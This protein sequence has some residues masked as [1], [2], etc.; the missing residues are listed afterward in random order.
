MVVDAGG[1]EKVLLGMRRSIS[2]GVGSGD[3]RKK[4][5]KRRERVKLEKASH[6]VASVVE[7]GGGMKARPRERR[8]VSDGERDRLE[9]LKRPVFVSGVVVWH[10]RSERRRVW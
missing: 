3:P 8:R 6:M 9:K 10:L 2:R 5:R 1:G 7:R 4:C